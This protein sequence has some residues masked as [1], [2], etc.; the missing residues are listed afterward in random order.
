MPRSRGFFRRK[1][2][3]RGGEIEP[4]RVGDVLPSAPEQSAREVADR[5]RAIVEAA[6][7]NAE[8]IERFAHADAERI[9][10]EAVAEGE[11][12]IARVR[13]STAA[14]EQRAAVLE[15]AIGEIVAGVSRSA[16][17][18][19]RDL[20]DVASSLELETSEAKKE[21][22]PGIAED[23]DLDGVRLVA[24]NLSLDGRSVDEARRE[25]T[26]EYPGVDLD[27]VLADVFGGAETPGGGPS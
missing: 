21:L 13:A 6:E 2:A 27:E 11:A 18:L 24:L 19:D 1:P 3:A 20:V 7:R 25:L 14:I 5:V 9:R 10:A 16:A 26:A 17:Q 15:E 23:I 4:I 8:E 22:E 12:H